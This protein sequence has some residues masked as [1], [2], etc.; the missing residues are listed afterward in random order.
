MIA[1]RQPEWV[2]AIGGRAFVRVEE[3]HPQDL[4][5]AGRASVKLEEFNLQDLVKPPWAFA[6][7]GVPR[8]GSRWSSGSARRR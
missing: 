5:I 4:A 7:L 2:G 8:M 1:V 6:T 3:S